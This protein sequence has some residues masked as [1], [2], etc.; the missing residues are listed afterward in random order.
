MQLPVK[1][2]SK[3]KNVFSSIRHYLINYRIIFIV[4]LL[5]VE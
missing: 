3:I 5:V 2:K 4:W 1:K